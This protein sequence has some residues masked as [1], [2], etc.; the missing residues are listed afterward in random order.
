MRTRDEKD[1]KL[2]RVRV[3]ELLV[4]VLHVSCVVNQN[5]RSNASRK[6]VA[7]IGMPTVEN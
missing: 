4:D 6:V 3:V 2:V 5:A 7:Q 1:S